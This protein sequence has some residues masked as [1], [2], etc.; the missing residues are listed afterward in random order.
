MQKKYFYVDRIIKQL[1]ITTLFLG[2]VFNTFGQSYYNVLGWIK[3]K[4]V[5]E[6]KKNVIKVVLKDN[7][8]T[9]FSES[10]KKSIE[11]N[12]T[13]T[14]YEF[15]TESEL[16][17]K[18]EHKDDVSL[19][20]YFDAMFEHLAGKTNYIMKNVPVIALTN[21]FRDGYYYKTDHMEL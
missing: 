6:I 13:F 18:Y 12:W 1:L 14:K 21:C 20:G 8:E 9:N 4:Q 11:E 2:V 5:N 3:T 10:L 19:F 7:D 16:S 15:I 17:S